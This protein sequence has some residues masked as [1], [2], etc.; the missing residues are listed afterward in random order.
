MTLADQLFLFVASHRFFDQP[1]NDPRTVQF[2]SER[3][4]IGEIRISIF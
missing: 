3:S 2:G 1:I 4:E